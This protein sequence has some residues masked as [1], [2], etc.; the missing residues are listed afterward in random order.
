MQEELIPEEKVRG[1]K[2][3][4]FVSK[5]HNQVLTVKPAR[6]QVMDG[7]VIPVPGEHIRFERG[8]FITSDKKEIEF[9][10]KHRL[11]GSTITEAAGV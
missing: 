9:I 2:A 10:R 8:E 6:T 1:T 7:I 5:C 11:F 3:A 4:K